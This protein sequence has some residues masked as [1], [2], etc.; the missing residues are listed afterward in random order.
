MSNLSIEV[1]CVTVMETTYNRANADHADLH[2]I[3]DPGWYW[4]DYDGP[5]V[6]PY[7][8]EREAW[9]DAPIPRLPGEEQ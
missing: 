3:F 9:E 6:G 1:F 8:T 7:T 2:T 5:A 4:R